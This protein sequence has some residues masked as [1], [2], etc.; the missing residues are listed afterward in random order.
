M[1]NLIPQLAPD[2]PTRLKIE[3]C[4]QLLTEFNSPVLSALTDN[5]VASGYMQMLFNLSGPRGQQLY[6]AVAAAERKD[7]ETK[8]DGEEATLEPYA[9]E[10]ST[11]AV[12]FFSD[13]A[14][15]KR[16]AKLLLY[17]L[18]FYETFAAPRLVNEARE[19][20]CP[21]ADSSLSNPDGKS[22]QPPQQ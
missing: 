4:K 17:F 12:Q 19:Q 5:I 15:Q 1:N 21:K 16:L 2:E 6:S 8:A 13:P 9:Q 14:N 10:L 3:R 20:A 22:D 18:E 7:K 11:N